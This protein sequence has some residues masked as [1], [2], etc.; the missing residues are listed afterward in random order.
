MEKVKSRVKKAK[1]NIKEFFENFFHV[2]RK[3]DMVILPGNIA[4][5]ICLAIIPCFSLLSLGAS[6][7]NLSTNVI[8]DF[9]AS[10]FSTDIADLIL[11]VDLN[12]IF[13]LDFFITIIVGLYVASNGADAIIL[14]SNTIY[15]TGN[16][17]WVKR[18]LKALL[19]MFI[20]VVLLLFMLIVPVFGET[21]ISLVEE[22]N[23]NQ[24]ITNKIVAIFELIQ[25]P[26]T[27]LI[28]F[29]I[30]KV[31]YKIAPNKKSETRVVNY[32]AIFT[33]VMFI[34]GTKF[35]SIYVT[36][37][38]SYTALYGGLANIIVL[39]IWIY[40]LSFI[41]TVGMALNCEKDEANML[42]NGKY[43]NK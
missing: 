32:G 1:V 36:H 7:L 27:W 2:L 23:M 31:L 25:G 40:F 4:F 35:Y 13:G 5:Y 16:K 21:I 15:N 42:K 38:A 26:I 39:M 18:R 14:A 11:G 43:D 34:V 41:F 33:T 28:M 12:N 8:Y 6:L 29:I 10:S 20:L 24:N 37:Y 3:P 17:S 9:I 19:M 22:V 30:I